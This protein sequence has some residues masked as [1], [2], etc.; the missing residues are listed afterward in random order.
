MLLSYPRI[1]ANA[2]LGAIINSNAAVAVYGGNQNKHGDHHAKTALKVMEYEPQML[3]TGTP[4][5]R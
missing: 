4:I 3:I 5:Q 1:K 2:A